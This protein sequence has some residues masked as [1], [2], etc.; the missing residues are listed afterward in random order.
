MLTL[1]MPQSDPAA[2]MKRSAS[3][4]SVVKI[5]DDRPCGDPVIERDRVVEVAVAQHVEDRGERLLQHRPVLGRDF[6]DRR[7]DVKAAGDRLDLLQAVADDLAAS[8]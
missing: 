4:R 3:R 7:A 5:D 6:D 8:P 2:D 1:A